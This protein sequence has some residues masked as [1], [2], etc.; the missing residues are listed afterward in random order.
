MPNNKLVRITATPPQLPTINDYFTTMAQRQGEEISR[1]KQL[2][3]GGELPDQ[4]NSTTD[5]PGADPWIMHP[6][7]LTKRATRKSN[8]GPAGARRGSKSRPPKKR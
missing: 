5:K 6:T 7:R 4:A 8:T 1:L 3:L 2:A